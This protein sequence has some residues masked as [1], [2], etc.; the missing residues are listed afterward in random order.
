MAFFYTIFLDTKKTAGPRGKRG[1]KRGRAQRGHAHKQG[2]DD[3]DEE[4]FADPLGEDNENEE[5]EEAEEETVSGKKAWLNKSNCIPNFLCPFCDAG[6]VRHDSYQ[7][8][9]GQHK[10]QLNHGSGGTLDSAAA[11]VVSSNL[12]VQTVSK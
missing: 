3:D 9:L 4:E 1:P 12:D 8:H 5:E 7:S 6:F 2:S 10:K 11:P